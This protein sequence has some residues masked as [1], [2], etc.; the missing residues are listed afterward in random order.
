MQIILAS[1]SPRRK[2]LL[3][4][5][6]LNFEIIIPQVDESCLDD[7]LPIDFVKRLSLDKANAV[8]K[9]HPDAT[10][11]AAD[12]AVVVDQHI[13]GKPANHDEAFNYLQL[14][15]NRGHQ[16][17]TGYSILNTQSQTAITRA[18]C[19]DVYFRDLSDDEINWYIATGE[20]FDKAG[21][22]AIQGIA[23]AFITHISGSHTNV[24]GLPL[25][26]VYSD[27]KSLGLHLRD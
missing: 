4:Q 3:A 5:I 25:A 14:L 21:A 16:V 11:I 18:I 9:K 12:T 17:Y 13:L 27:L 7:E 1:A 20:P 2:D 22:Y 26:E 15:K 19:T 24:I 10:I 6:G 23:G 8:N